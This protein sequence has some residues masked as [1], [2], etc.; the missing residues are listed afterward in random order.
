MI[1]SVRNVSMLAGAALF[2]VVAFAAPAH[3]DDVDYNVSINPSI[4]MTIPAGDIVLNVDPTSQPFDSG[5]T[6][7]LVSTNNSLGYHLLMTAPSTNLV[8]TD[9]SY[10]VIPTLDALDGGYT[11]TSFVAN[12]WGYKIGEGNYLP[13]ATNATIKETDTVAESDPTNFTIAAKVDFHQ[14]AGVYDTV[15]TFTAVANLLPVYMQDL[16]DSICPE[17]VPL[18]VIDIR[19]SEQYLVQRLA[20]GK[21]WMLDNLR[22][23][24]TQ[25]SLDSL[26]GNTNA[27]DETLGYLKNGGGSSPYATNAVTTSGWVGG[28]GEEMNYITPFIRNDL[29]NTINSP[30][31]GQG[32]GKNGLYY[33]YCAISAGSYC[34]T[35]G[36]TGD[37]KYDICPAGWRLPTS[38][39]ATIPDGNYSRVIPSEANEFYNL[40]LAYN[41]NV[42]DFLTALSLPLSGYVNSGNG[43]SA[44]SQGSGNRFWTG[45]TASGMMYY[46]TTTDSSAAFTY[47]S[48]RNNGYTARCIRDPRTLDDIT[49]LQEVKPIIVHNTPVNSSNTLLDAR[50]D[51]EY[52]VAK[53]ADNNFWLLDNLRLDPTQ[54][55]LETLKG[56][57]NAPDTALE[58]FKNGGGTS[59]YPASGVS[60][61]WTSS[62]QDAYNLPYVI[63]SYKGIESGVTHGNA[64]G[65]RGVYYNYCAASA[66]SYC[67]NSY[68]SNSSTIGNANFDICPA[69]WRMPT[70]GTN[71]SSEINNLYIAYNSDD[72][73]LMNALSMPFSGVVSSG[74]V[75]LEGNQGVG[76]FWSS[77]RASQDLIE[78]MY[79]LDMKSSGV[80]VNY[81]SS[82]Y[83]GLSVRC[84]STF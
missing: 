2:G 82:R 12:K 9:D 74:G 53:L 20:D 27:S 49:Y 5:S 41:S 69:G 47:S 62:S 84:I 28:S 76:R 45:S 32:S 71:E 4:N 29:K 35:T 75:S 1:R 51:E 6:T 73:N 81:I 64:S 78:S 68:V 44:Y 59:P 11:E 8:K 14:T 37:S 79:G 46:L 50:D 80:A 25:V 83:W 15:I 42:G 66:G 24:P 38:G 23:D 54:V 36:V 13:F 39:T 40:Y 65:K 31:Y 70:G 21:C 16:D 57:T 60:S 72:D 43:G 58:Y 48:N 7:I 67:Y 19:D 61:E 17:D 33:N 22:L 30:T 34:G 52:L 77:T 3:A 26:K 63:T 55:S 10:T 56:N 18:K